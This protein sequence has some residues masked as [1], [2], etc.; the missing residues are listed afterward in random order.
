[1]WSHFALQQARGACGCSLRRLA[2]RDIAKWRNR[3]ATTCKNTLNH[4][5]SATLVSFA[6][7][8]Y[9]MSTEPRHNA[10]ILLG[11]VTRAVPV[12]CR[13]SLRTK[14]PHNMKMVKR[15]RAGGYECP[16]LPA[17]TPNWASSGSRNAARVI[18]PLP[19]PPVHPVPSSTPSPFDSSSRLRFGLADQLPQRGAVPP[20]TNSTP[21]QSTR[22][23]YHTRRKLLIPKVNPSPEY[24]PAATFVKA[25]L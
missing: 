18:C 24:D 23:K 7:Q 19:T 4:R 13:D 14:H 9:G 8:S 1:M 5:H 16:F 10:P 6:S 17:Q 15:K 11:V 22:D 12:R 3:P 21:T 20:A 25:F 2:P